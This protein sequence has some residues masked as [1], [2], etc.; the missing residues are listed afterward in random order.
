MSIELFPYANIV[1]NTGNDRSSA[2]FNHSLNNINL[3][4]N[5]GVLVGTKIRDA[6][7]SRTSTA[8]TYNGQ[9]MTAVPSAAS[10]NEYTSG[11]FHNMKWWYLLAPTTAGSNA[12][13]VTYTAAVDADEVICFVLHGVDQASPF[14]AVNSANG[15]S[16]T[17][18]VGLTTTLDNAW[19]IAGAVMRRASGASYTPTFPALDL[20]QG[21]TG[22]AA[23]Q[24]ITYNDFCLATGAAGAKTLSTTN[25][26]SSAQW[27]IIAFQVNEATTVAAAHS[28]LSRARLSTRVGGLLT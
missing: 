12:V 9:S 27:S 19:V 5:F 18:S 24:D 8:V 26:T 14:G 1:A 10:S 22:T 21:Q 4:S 2:S 13:A 7:S 28:K 11:V 6:V 20:A 25:A 3:G 16:A 15:N 23:Q 17:P